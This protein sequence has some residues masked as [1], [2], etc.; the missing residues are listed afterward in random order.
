MKK[1]DMKLVGVRTYIDGVRV[2]R[3]QT[4][5]YD[6]S[7]LVQKISLTVDD[8]MVT[9]DTTVDWDE[10]FKMLRADFI[11]AF[12]AD[13]V[14]CDIQ[15]G[16]FN[17]TTKQENKVDWAQFEICAHKYVNIDGADYG[18]ALIN[19][20]KY[21]H[22]AKDGFLSLCL[23]RSPE[24][25]DPTCDICTHTFSYAI[26][27]HKQPLAQSDVAARAYAFNNP[28]EIA[29]SNVVADTFVKQN[30]DGVIVETVKP[31]ESGEGT[32]LRVYECKGKACEVALTPSVN[33]D[34]AYESDML[35]NIKGET[36]LAKLA[37]RPW[38]IKTIILK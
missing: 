13:E 35:E 30:N 2:V 11:P 4:F 15:F 17:R 14:N 19:D 25:P 18:F 32:L 36:D 5:K 8:N 28:V 7:T 20:C 12:F 31:A 6:K 26:L 33:Y 21:G 9:F 24:F 34:K 16:T 23:L 3:E 10:R 37:F 22:R 1:W 27:P 29:E 38:E